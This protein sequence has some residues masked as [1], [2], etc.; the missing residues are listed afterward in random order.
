MIIYVKP[1]R[2]KRP[3]Y[4]IADRQEPGIEESETERNVKQ[5][6]DAFLTVFKGIML[7]AGII[8]VIGFIIAGMS[9]SL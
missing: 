6:M 8:A 7:F 3:V 2:N 4:I 9:L 1:G 5:L